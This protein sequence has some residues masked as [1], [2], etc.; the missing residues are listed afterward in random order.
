MD[1]REYFEQPKNRHHRQYEAVRAYLYEK[2][3]ADDVAKKFG[4]TKITIYSLA[5]DF[6]KRMADGQLE[7]YFF[8]KPQLGRNKKQDEKKLKELSDR[9]LLSLTVNEMRT[10]RSYF[11]K[12]GREPTDMELET[13]AQ[14]WSEHCKHKTLTGIIEYEGPGGE[15]RIDNLLGKTVFA[16]TKELTSKTNG[17]KT[18]TECLTQRRISDIISEFDMLGVINA[19]VISKG[20]YGRT[21]EIRIDLSL[22]IL[23]K[24]NNIL[25]NNLNL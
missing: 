14:T 8:S 25:I 17:N 5:R 23:Q 12:A 20:R 15:E 9:R 3:T 6:K 19:K 2:Q 18:K 22:H 13:I 24:K 10:I 21:R 1:I 7:Q 11:H 4:Y 16:V